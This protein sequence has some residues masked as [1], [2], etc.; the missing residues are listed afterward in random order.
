MLSQL[1]KVLAA[2]ALSL[3]AAT[4]AHAADKHKVA[5]VPQLIGI[6]YFNAMEAGGNRAAKD[7]GVDF[8]YSGPVDTNPVDQ[9]QIV[10]NLID[11]GVEA[12]SVSVLD[13]SSIAPVVESAKAKGIKLF[14][15]DSDA[16]DSGRAVYVAQATDEGLGTTIIDELVKRVGED[17]TIGIVS[18]EATASNLNAWIGFMQKEA[19][20]KYPKLKLLAPQFAG[21]TAERAAQISGDLMAANPDIKAIIAVASSTCPG[22]AQAIETAGKI[23]SVIGTG[24]CSP[25]TARS[26]LKS[27]AFGFTVLWD[28][29]QLG[30]LTVWAGKQLI[31]GKS[32]EAENKV[33]GLDKPATYDAAKGIL[34][35]GPPAVFTK[36]NVD[37]FNF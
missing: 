14:T 11:Q 36:D 26:Y 23:G 10:Q 12:V 34:L 15:S 13:A 8:V 4:A 16:P 3:V 22:V 35:L 31:D 18:G 27:G 24:Y 33:A 28:P 1:R 19:A 32:F 21:G 7:L 9:L 17:A 30:Y 5:F 2:S 6:P 25:N 29:E 20:A 37:Q